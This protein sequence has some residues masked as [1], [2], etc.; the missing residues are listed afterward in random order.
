MLR[1]T[2][3]RFLWLIPTMLAMSFIIFVIM[4]ATPGSPLD[5]MRANANTLTP[6]AQAAMAAHYGLDKPLH[7]QYLTFLWNVLHLDFGISYV[8]R[9]RQV[10]AIIA[11]TFP[12]SLALGTFSLIFASVI[13]LALGIVAAMRQHGWVD[14]V[15]TSISMLFISTPN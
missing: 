10:S 2:V 1:Y 5:P 12:I 14:Y 9:D 11:G 4:H 6:Q 3:E 15:A 13:G 7:E 8:F